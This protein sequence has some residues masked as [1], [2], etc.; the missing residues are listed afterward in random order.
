[1]SIPLGSG[2]RPQP[3]MLG[4]GM[5]PMSLL[6]MGLLGGLIPDGGNM[7]SVDPVAS[8]NLALEDTPEPRR[9]LFSAMMGG[10]SGSGTFSETITPQMMPIMLALW[11]DEERQKE[12]ERRNRPKK[13]PK[14][15]EDWIMQQGD[16]TI[17]MWMDRDQQMDEDLAIYRLNFK[18][19]NIEDGEFVILNDPRVIVDKAV[20]M[21][22]AQ[23]P[24]IK[25]IA[26]V[27]DTR[28]QAQK[29]EN[30]LRWQWDR[31][32]REWRRGQLQQS[33]RYAMAHFGCLRGWITVRMHYDPDHTDR[34]TSPIKC[35]P[36]DPRQVY[37]MPGKNGMKYVIHKYP[38]TVAEL[39]DEWPEAEKVYGDNHDM[40]EV[41]EVKAYYD[42]HFH[43]VWVDNHILKKPTEHGY[44]INPWVIVPCQG[45]P[46][47]ATDIDETGWNRYAGVAIFDSIRHAYKQ[48]NRTMSQLATETAR[49]ANPPRIYY[50]DPT[51]EE[52]KEIILSPGHTN[53]AYA[54]ERVD[55]LQLSARPSDV[56]PLMN[57]LSSNIEKGGLPDVLWGVGSNT[58]GLGMSVM[59]DAARDQLFAVVDA[60]EEAM[61]QIH[62]IALTL[63]QNV[64]EGEIGFWITDGSGE[65]ASGYTISSED[66]EAVGTET[67]VIYKNIT[68]RDR[69]A[70]ANLGI[71]LKESR[72]LSPTTVREEYL[73]IDNPERE[74]ERLLH[75]MMYLNEE[76]VEKFFIP[77]TLAKITPELV[78]AYQSFMS[79]GQGGGMPPGMPPG[80]PGLPGPQG[81]G[82]PPPPPQMGPGGIPMQ[83][84]QQRTGINPE[85]ISP[86][87]QMGANPLTQALGSAMG[88]MGM[89]SPPGISGLGGI[90]PSPTPQF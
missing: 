4:N 32:E 89:Q 78:E 65:V 48:M 40:T 75:D 71:S 41:V 62:E 81:M 85:T 6:G 63:V 51:D 52:P 18:P 79:Q 19:K 2:S 77:L 21:L 7:D 80:M 45:S 87:A 76:M 25:C 50:Y 53:Y 84:P 90:L 17:M 69:M 55:L 12:E 73:D 49:S 22:A 9:N 13:P 20:N 70:L 54:G 61:Q 42:D 36:Y 35:T 88:G 5:D 23:H 66:V 57:S 56:Q 1:M 11:E 64:H 15:K 38:I 10:E 16:R 82:P 86:L 44:G 28:E 14:P 31:W 58:T 29:I 37:P 67:K 68:P 26:P 3:D 8:M 34:N 27:E 24:I 59:S 83:A 43:A 74:Q 30:W 46:I 33:I 60:M 47:R 39:L 72:L